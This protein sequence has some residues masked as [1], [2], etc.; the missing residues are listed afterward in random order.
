MVVSLTVRR[1]GYFFENPEMFSHTVLLT[2]R[3]LRILQYL[4]TECHGLLQDYLALVG[5]LED[6]LASGVDGR[7]KVLEDV[8]LGLDV[9][10]GVVLEQVLVLV[11][12]THE[13]VEDLLDDDEHVGLEELPGEGG[14][15]G[16][17]NV[18]DGLLEDARRDVL[19]VAVLLQHLQDRGENAG[20]VAFDINEK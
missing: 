12:V 14:H 8:V 1:K 17:L 20:R 11:R 18:D 5:H 19:S 16:V 2:R 13:R 15:D 9:L 4:D 3:Q 10:D 7:D 6:E